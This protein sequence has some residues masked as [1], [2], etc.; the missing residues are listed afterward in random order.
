MSL[1][2]RLMRHGDALPLPVS[3][4]THPVQLG[5]ARRRLVPLPRLPSCRRRRASVHRGEHENRFRCEP[6]KA[7]S[8]P[9]T[10][11]RSRW[12]NDAIALVFTRPRV[13]ARANRASALAKNDPGVLVRSGPLSDHEFRLPA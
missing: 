13:T 9:Q 2:A 5:S 11:Q 1:D 8:R 10:S 7:D 4:L 12:S 6:Q 3:L